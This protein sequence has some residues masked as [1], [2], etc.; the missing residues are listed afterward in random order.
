VTNECS[1]DTRS[2]T[3]NSALGY[4]LSQ[5]VFI[6]KIFHKVETDPLTKGLSRSDILATG[7]ANL[8]QLSTDS[9]IVAS[10][11]NAYMEGI[12]DVLV[13]AL[14]SVCIAH[15]PLVGMEWLKY[16][17]ANVVR[18]ESREGSSLEVSD[19]DTHAKDVVV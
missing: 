2:L 15:L 13:L 19:S 14:V 4:A 6:T 3:A 7:A 16:P 10:V 17:K 12:R 1:G 11:R 18:S 9:Q 8:Q 5:T